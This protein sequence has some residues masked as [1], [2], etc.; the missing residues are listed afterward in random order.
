M[1]V[2]RVAG[3]AIAFDD[4]FFDLFDLFVVS[5]IYHSEF[6]LLRM[7]SLISLLTQ[8]SLRICLSKFYP[9]AFLGPTK[10]PRRVP[11]EVAD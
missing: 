9:G 8:G 10:G 6:N 4:G 2:V 11:T 7:S 3:A 5:T 1:E